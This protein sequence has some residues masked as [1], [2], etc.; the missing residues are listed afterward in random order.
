MEP[1][2]GHMDLNTLFSCNESLITSERATMDTPVSG[3]TPPPEDELF[4]EY[5]LGCS[6][7]NHIVKLVER[8]YR[9]RPE[10]LTIISPSNNG[11][12][13]LMLKSINIITQKYLD[14]SSPSVHIP[15]VYIRAPVK[16]NR[17]RFF[18]NLCD[19][20]R[21]PV[22]SRMQI[23]FLAYRAFNA[24]KDAG[25]KGVF[26]D[27]LHHLV[28]GTK[29]DCGAL[30]DD[31]KIIG[32]D[33]GIPV[34]CAGTMRAYMAIEKDEQYL[35]RLPPIEL[36]MWVLDEQFVGLLRSLELH[37]GIVSGIIAN[38]QIGELIWTYSKGLLGRIIRIVIDAQDH[39]K[40]D[41][42]T[43]I[44]ASHIKRAGSKDLPWSQRG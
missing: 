38:Q 42:N 21:V 11:K 15:V 34:I 9:L 28:A 13:F 27:E 12:T 18:A 35:S 33:L 16:A 44:L 14:S 25:V 24:M 1:G 7:V 41:G 5:P 23:D 3:T 22:S 30:L 10:G 19:K 31:I 26:I 40:Q 32:D 37:L 2:R 39:A 20:V 29:K 36:P 8:P 43:T 6:V 4:I 17:R